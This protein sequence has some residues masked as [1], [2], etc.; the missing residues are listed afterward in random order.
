MSFE[1]YSNIFCG[2]GHFITS[3]DVYNEEEVFC[4]C[5]N[6]DR[7]S[8]LIDET[9]GCFCDELKEDESCPACSKIL[10]EENIIGK[11][12][13]KC[14]ECYDGKVGVIKSY[15]TGEVIQIDHQFCKGTSFIEIPIYNIPSL[16]R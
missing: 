5:G 2:K 9:N 15:K 4:L 6:T 16:R 13:M 12:P 8:E 1:G 3:Q 10:R 14:P 7:F 11:S